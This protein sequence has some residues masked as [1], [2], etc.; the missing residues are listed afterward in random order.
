MIER[1]LVERVQ[2]DTQKQ[3]KPETTSHAVISDNTLGHFHSEV[4]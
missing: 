1:R 3:A 2:H 4:T